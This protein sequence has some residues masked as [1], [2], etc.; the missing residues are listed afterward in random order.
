VWYRTTLGSRIFWR[1]PRLRSL[2]GPERGGRR[3]HRHG[4]G[5]H[6]GLRP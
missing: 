4:P 5:Q 6:R 2:A 3:T 1:T